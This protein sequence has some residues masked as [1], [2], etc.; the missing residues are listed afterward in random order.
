[1]AEQRDWV[2]TWRKAKGE[3]VFHTRHTR[4]YH[5]LHDTSWEVDSNETYDNYTREL[6]L[7]QKLT[8][9]NGVI[10]ERSRIRSPKKRR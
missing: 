10:P 5:P 7:V 4:A 6:A 1:M 8:E 3:C 9:E 2:H